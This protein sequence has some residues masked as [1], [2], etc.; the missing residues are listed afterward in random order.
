MIGEEE[1]PQTDELTYLL[2]ASAQVQA[3]AVGG[4]AAQDI[5]IIFCVDIS[6]S[7]CVS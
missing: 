2:E 3:A 7:M 5:S 1:V 6:G 4:N